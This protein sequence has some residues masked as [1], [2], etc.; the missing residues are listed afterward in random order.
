LIFASSYPVAP[1]GEM[2]RRYKEAG[3]KDEV[4]E[5]VFYKNAARALKLDQGSG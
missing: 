2:V 1:M 4:I 5:K 3:L